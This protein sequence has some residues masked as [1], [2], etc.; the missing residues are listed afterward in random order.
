ML[1]PLALAFVGDTVYDLFV[2]ETLV[3]QANRPVKKLHFLAVEKVRA[4]AQAIFA[5][6]IFD[7]LTQEEKDVFMRGRNAHTGH[8]PKNA[9]VEDYHYATALETL[10]G[11]LYLSG[12][13]ERLRELFSFIHINEKE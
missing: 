5:K 2:R 1:S 3:C 8:I 11:F 4:Q 10:F 7:F 9:S 12:Q 6:E 13:I